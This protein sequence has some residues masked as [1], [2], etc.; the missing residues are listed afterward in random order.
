MKALHCS[1]LNES[2][3]LNVTF[4][5]VRQQNDVY[6][7]G[8]FAIAFAAEIIDGKPPMD[9]YLDVKTMRSN[10]TLLGKGKTLSL[11]KISN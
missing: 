6:N 11:P 1:C 3:K 9:S 4:L 5:P 10:L 7:C 2:G 8:V